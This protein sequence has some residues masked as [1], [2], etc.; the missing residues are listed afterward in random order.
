MEVTAADVVVACAD[1]VL[2]DC[3]IFSGCWLP[4]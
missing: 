1:A 3:L 4:P 2:W